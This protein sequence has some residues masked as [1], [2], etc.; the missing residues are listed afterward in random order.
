MSQNLS[1]GSDTLVFLKP[2]PDV[3][4]AMTVVS[5]WV[6]GNGYTPA[7]INT[8]LQVADY[9]LVSH[10][11]AHQLVVVTHEKPADTPNKVKIPNVCVG[12]D[13]KVMTPFEMLR[14]EHARFV[15]G[16]A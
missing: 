2:D 9:W 8:F 1:R 12:L 16:A 6:T 15:L 13:I 7:A 5:S 14:H 4:S 10:A 3:L 11:L